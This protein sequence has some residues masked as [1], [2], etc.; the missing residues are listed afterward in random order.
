[1]KR[2]FVLVPAFILVCLFAAAVFVKQ[3]MAGEPG[4]ALFKQHCAICHVD[5]GNI[6]NPK[7]TLHKKDLDANN[8][9]AA[10]D[11]IK[12][13]RNPGPGMTTFDEKIIPDKQAHEIAEHIL[14][15][16]N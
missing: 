9:K 12:T 10:A 2:G 7:K 16:F 3:G 1:M 11:I 5:G 14:K 15:T 6:I 4:E 13:M 8:I